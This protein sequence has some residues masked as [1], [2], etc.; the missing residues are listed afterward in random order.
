[1]SKQLKR[2]KDVPCA[3][4]GKKVITTESITQAFRVIAKPLSKMLES[5]SFKFWK[6]QKDVWRLLENYAKA[7]P[8]KS[9][10]K[11]LEKLSP[12]S[13]VIFDFKNV[14][15]MDSTGIGVIVGRY[16]KYRPN[17]LTFVIKN[18]NK[19]VDRILK[20]TGIYS[21]IPKLD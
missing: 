4:C 17:F 8:D 12:M 14:G 3:C 7:F 20:M 2:V 11:I 1:M 5:G 13:E 16:K 18:P 9:L 6:T 15:F 21:L 19:T 10:D